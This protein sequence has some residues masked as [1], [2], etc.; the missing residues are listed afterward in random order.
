MTT[1]D[2]HLFLSLAIRWAHVAAMA[3]LLGGA[4]LLWGLALQPATA[5]REARDDLLL[6]AAGTYEWFFWAAIGLLVM[7][8]IGNLG[9]FG[10]GL[11][12]GEMAWGGRFIVKLVAV[13]IFL[14]GSLVR[15]L[16]VLHLG[17]TR[18]PAPRSRRLLRGGYAGTALYTAVVLGAAVVLAH[19]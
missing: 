18:P 4:V 7:T 10:V 9:A 8:G 5:E 15:S 3:L 2:L 13:L 14:P 12:P 17:T 19:G 16:L 1:L 6:A 11:P